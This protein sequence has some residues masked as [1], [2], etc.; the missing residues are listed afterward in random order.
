MTSKHV[1]ARWAYLLLTIF[2]Y[3]LGCGMPI[4]H[5]VRLQLNICSHVSF[6]NQIPR[7]FAF[8][9][10]AF[11]FSTLG[12]VIRKDPDRLQKWSVVYVSSLEPHIRYKCYLI[13]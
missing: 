10:S 5:R 3:E 7:A 6:I 2:Q 13:I 1:I 4:G 9:L 11:E 12:L 8:P